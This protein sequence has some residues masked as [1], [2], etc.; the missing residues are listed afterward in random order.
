MHFADFFGLQ[1][2]HDLI[3][4]SFWQNLQWLSTQLINQQHRR[5]FCF[6]PRDLEFVWVS[7]DRT[8]WSS[9]GWSEIS[10]M[11]F[12]Y[13]QAAAKIVFKKKIKLI[14]ELS[15]QQM[16]THLQSLNN[17]ENSWREEEEEEEIGSFQSG[18]TL[19]LKSIP[20]SH[21]TNIFYCASVVVVCVLSTGTINPYYDRSCWIAGSTKIIYIFLHIPRMLNKYFSQRK[22]FCRGE[23]WSIFLGDYSGIFHE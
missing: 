1:N 20:P 9:H 12:D 8:D 11:D 6:L 4:W 7:G 18:L 19:N 22:I 3:W 17:D 10:V 15:K 23:N 2:L 13:L 5:K 21:T 14:K 16:I